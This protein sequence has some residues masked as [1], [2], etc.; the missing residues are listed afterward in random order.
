MSRSRAAHS[1]YTL[2]LV[3]RVGALLRAGVGVG[4]C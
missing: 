2:P 3:G 4:V 1:V